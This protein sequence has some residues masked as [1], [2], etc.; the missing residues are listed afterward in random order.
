MH[1]AWVPKSPKHCAGE[2]TSS[3]RLV[4]YHFTF[5]NVSESEFILYIF[6]SELEYSD[7][8][9]QYDIPSPN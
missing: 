8:H 1:A 9:S 4:T 5:W 7:N 2:E 3:A 6:L